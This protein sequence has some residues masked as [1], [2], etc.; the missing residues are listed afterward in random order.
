[1]IGKTTTT[2]V[3]DGP[4]RRVRLE[5]TYDATLDDVW[6]LWTTKEGIESWWGP[7]G[8]KVETWASGQMRRMAVAKTCAHEC[9]MR[10]SSV[11][12]LRSSSDLRSA[13]C[14]SFSDINH[15]YFNHR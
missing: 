14:F 15:F 11:I 2:T 3:S 1:M 12:L 10:S 8:F 6:D 5:R 9:R 4:R 13:G 7:P